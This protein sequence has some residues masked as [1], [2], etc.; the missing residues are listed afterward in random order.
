MS[1]RT[2]SGSTVST[3]LKVA[4]CA[5]MTSLRVPVSARPGVKSESS[6]SSSQRVFG[7]GSFTSSLFG[8]TQVR[9]AHIDHPNF[10]SYKRDDASVV[11][12]DYQRRAFTYLLGAGTAVAGLQLAKSLVVDFLDTMSAS[13]DV[14]ALAKMEV[15]LST[16]PVGKN[17]TFKWRGKP[18]FVRHRPQSEID[19]ERAVDV[20]SLRHKE[21]DEDRVTKPEWLVV[22]GICTHLGCVPIAN[23]GEFGGYFCPCHGSHYDAS[24]RIRKGPAPFNLE[25]PDHEFKDEE[26]KLVIG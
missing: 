19:T 10:D 15:D 1:L 3:A 20:S 24:G 25:I 12:A 18:V 11:E 16:I 23:A 13:A 22:L 26:N 14:L 4:R 7:T 6:S 9:L 8:K 17:V 21:S 2:F 5:T